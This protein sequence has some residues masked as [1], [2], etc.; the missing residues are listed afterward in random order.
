MCGV[1]HEG[2]APANYQRPQHVWGLGETFLCIKFVRNRMGGYGRKFDVISFLTICFI[3]R[4]ILHKT[5][6][7]ITCRA[8]IDLIRLHV[9]YCG[10]ARR[11]PCY[12]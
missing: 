12:F 11:N 4:V 6:Q 7:A 2:I 9:M 8:C 10:V 3:V 5:A 1:C